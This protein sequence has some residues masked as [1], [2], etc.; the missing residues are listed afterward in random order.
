MTDSSAPSELVTA[1]YS[2]PADIKAR[3][4]REAKEQD[5]KTSQYIRRILS[6]YFARL[7]GK[8]ARPAPTSDPLPVAA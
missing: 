1:A 8:D 6:D 7:D 2:I 4:E 3:I 5:L